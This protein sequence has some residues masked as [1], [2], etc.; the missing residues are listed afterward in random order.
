[1]VWGLDRGERQTRNG[2]GVQVLFLRDADGRTHTRRLLTCTHKYK[3][4]QADYNAFCKGRTPTILL[5]RYI[6]NFCTRV[7]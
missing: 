2:R 5:W 3:L 7:W 6:L 1:M 4:V